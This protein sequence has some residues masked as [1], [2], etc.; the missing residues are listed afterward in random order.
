MFEGSK[1]DKETKKMGK[2]GSAKEVAFDKMQKKMPA[3]KKG[4]MVGKK[5]C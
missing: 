2:E 4:G 5:K 3:F 1:K